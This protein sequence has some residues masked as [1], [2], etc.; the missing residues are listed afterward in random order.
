MAMH[1]ILTQ[2]VANLGKAGELVTV[3][4]GYGRNYLLPQ[5]MAVSASA[6]N[7]TRLEHDRKVIEKRVAKEKANAQSIADRLNGMTLQFERNVGEDD[8]LFGS[9]SNRDIGD[10]LKKAGIDLDHRKIELEHPVKALGKYE[11]IV[12][13]GAGVHANLKFWVVAKDK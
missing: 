12:R 4:P 5:G 6:R 9:V 2:D 1:I 8:K 3:K 11:V 10:Q 13:L 7:V